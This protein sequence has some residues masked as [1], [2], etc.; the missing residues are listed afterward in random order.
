NVALHELPNLVAALEHVRK[1]ATPE[2]VVDLATR[3]EA[4]LAPL[5]RAKALARVVEIRAEA[6]QKLGAWGHAQYQAEVSAIERL[7]ADGRLQEA[8]EAARRLLQKA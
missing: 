2:R 1:S 3:L 5:A 4:L 6:A 7:I 8:T